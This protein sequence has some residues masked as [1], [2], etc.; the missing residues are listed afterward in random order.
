MPNPS[1]YWRW[2]LFLIPVLEISFVWVFFVFPQLGNM[3]FHWPRR[4]NFNRQHIGSI[5]D[6]HIKLIWLICVFS[7]DDFPKS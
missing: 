3:S 1:Y 5:K 2:V 7:K 6:V 4:H